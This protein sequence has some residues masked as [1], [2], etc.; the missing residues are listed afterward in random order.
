MN[1][2]TCCNLRSRS[3]GMKTTTPVRTGQ[4][5]GAG[6]AKLRTEICPLQH[7]GFELVL[8]LEA[9]LI[10]KPVPEDGSSNNLETWKLQDGVFY[11]QKPPYRIMWQYFSITEQH[12][13]ATT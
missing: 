1:I 5:N 3:T 7:Y 8:P 11:S 2:Y 13:R 9:F 6:E 4:K 12:C 10:Q